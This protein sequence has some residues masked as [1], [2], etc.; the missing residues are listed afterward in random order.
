MCLPPHL[1][2]LGQVRGPEVKSAFGG[3]PDLWLLCRRCL[4]LTDPKPSRVCIGSG[5]ELHRHCFALCW[6]PVDLTEALMTLPQRYVISQLDEVA[7]KAGL[8]SHR[9]TETEAAESS[10]LWL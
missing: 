3:E 2:L 5:V 6:Q 7:I 9:S 8:M 10:T 4:R 1:A